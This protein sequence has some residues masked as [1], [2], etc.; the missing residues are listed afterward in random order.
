MFLSKHT[1]NKLDKVRG[2]YNNT[3]AIDEEKLSFKI[4]G[5]LSLL[6]W[7]R[8]L[9]LSLLLKLPSGKLEP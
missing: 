2:W 9:K 3:D 6:N 8:A 1:K 5:R 7:S 4:L